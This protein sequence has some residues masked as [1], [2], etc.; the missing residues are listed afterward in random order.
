MVGG[1]LVFGL[2]LEGEVL[3]FGGGYVGVGEWGLG[4]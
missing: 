4:C 1:E 2:F 3:G